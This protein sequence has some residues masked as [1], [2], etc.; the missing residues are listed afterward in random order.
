MQIHNFEKKICAK[1][2]CIYIPHGGNQQI[3][4]KCNPKPVSR[5]TQPHERQEKCIS[6]LDMRIREANAR[7]ISYGK[8]VALLYSQKLRQRGESK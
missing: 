8:Y 1:C 6:R 4:D 5:D 2:R 7:G 3:C